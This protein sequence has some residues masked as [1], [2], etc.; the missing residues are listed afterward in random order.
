M[1][2]SS[3]VKGYPWEVN[4]KVRSEE[5]EEKV[6]GENKKCERKERGERENEQEGRK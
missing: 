5:R 2:C 4:P 1:D 6:S 3:L